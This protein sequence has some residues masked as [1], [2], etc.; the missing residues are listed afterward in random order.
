MEYRGYIIKPSKSM[1]TLYQVAT[2]GQGGK[3]P[4]VLDGLFTSTGII[5]S[6]I[7]NYVESKPRKEVKNGET[8]TES[9][10]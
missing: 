10:D 6:I 1:P 7:D 9:R 4:S 5:K 2:A 3:I 8:R